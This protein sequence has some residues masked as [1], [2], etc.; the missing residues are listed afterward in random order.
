MYKELRH[1]LGK[2]NVYRFFFNVVTDLLLQ[3]R[4]KGN[5]EV[6][7]NSLNTQAF[8]KSHKSVANSILL[9]QYERN[10]T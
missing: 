4:S 3:Q 10:K 2:L 6:N 9:A 5:D 8:G 1:F 7:W